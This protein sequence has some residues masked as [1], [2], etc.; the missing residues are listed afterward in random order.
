[1]ADTAKLSAA[2]RNVAELLASAQGSNIVIRTGTVHTV[3][4]GAAADGNAAVVVTIDGNNI[5]AQYDA[6]YASPTVGHVVWVVF[7]DGSPIIAGRLIGA[8]VF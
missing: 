6:S 3:T 5:P 7:V 2:I 8:P 1:M 4:A